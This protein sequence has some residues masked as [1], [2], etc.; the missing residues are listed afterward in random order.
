MLLNFKAIITRR[1]RREEKKMKF[2]KIDRIK[3]VFDRKMAKNGNGGEEDEMTIE[4]KCTET[5][6]H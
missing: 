4:Y 3:A 6:L 5:R 2:A 1:W